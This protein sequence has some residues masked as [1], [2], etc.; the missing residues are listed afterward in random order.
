MAPR[1][2]LQSVRF[3][4]KDWSLAEARDW[5]KKHYYHYGSVTTTSRQYRFRQREPLRGKKYVTKKIGDG[6]IE[7]VFF[8][9]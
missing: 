1:L 6:S 2:N 8:R 7:Y 4:R 9:P 3:E 5:L